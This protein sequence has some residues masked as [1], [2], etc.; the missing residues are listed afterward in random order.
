MVSILGVTM[1]SSSA[2]RFKMALGSVVS[3]AVVI[4][5]LAS[6]FAFTFGRRRYKKE[7]PNAKSIA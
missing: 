6:F 3:V 2:L 5:G 1:M 7:V 4:S